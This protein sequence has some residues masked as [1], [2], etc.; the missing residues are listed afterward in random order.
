MGKKKK[1]TMGCGFT[2]YL[3]IAAILFI[4]WVLY[5]HYIGRKERVPYE[6]EEC[7]RQMGLV[8]RYYYKM[9]LEDGEWPSPPDKVFSKFVGLPSVDPWG[10][11][12]KFVERDGSLYLYSL[13]PDKTDDGSTNEYIL[14]P[15]YP[16]SSGDITCWL[17]SLTDKPPV[18]PPARVKRR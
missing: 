3:V 2:G 9:A 6:V 16:F 17:R 5:D 18:R 10:S 7:W 8:N 12:F 1:E 15:K 14:D 13:G 4:L 11:P